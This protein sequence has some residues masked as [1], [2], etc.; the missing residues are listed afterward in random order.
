MVDHRA[1]AGAPVTETADTLH[2]IDPAVVRQELE[3]AG[4]VYDGEIKVL[5]NP[6]D[7]HTKLVFD[8]AVRGHTDQFVYRFKRPA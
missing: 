7:D 4:F 8:P 6:A 5:E 1:K 3:A 2:R